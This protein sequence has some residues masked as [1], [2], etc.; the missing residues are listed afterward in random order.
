MEPR[1]LASG[2]SLDPPTFPKPLRRYIAI[3]DPVNAHTRPQNPFE[4]KKIL[5]IFGD[6][7]TLVPKDKSEEFLKKVNVGQNGALETFAQEGVGHACTPLMV[8]K[9]AEFVWRHSLQA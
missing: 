7:D 5:A 6:K 3:R 2:L 4:G 1:A 9:M 8:E